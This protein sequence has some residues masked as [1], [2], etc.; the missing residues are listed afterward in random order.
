MKTTYYPWPNLLALAFCLVL[1]AGCTKAYKVRH[2]LEAADRDFQDQKYDKAEAEYQQALLL[3]RRDPVA[4]RQSVAVRQLGFIYFEEG[5]QAAFIYLKIAH[6][7]DNKNLQVQLKLAELYGASGDSNAIPLLGPVLQSD[8]ANEHALLLLV[9]LTQTN[10]L[11]SLRQR[12]ETQLQAGGQGAAVYHSALGWIDLRTQKINDAE[13]ELQKAVALD[14][15]LASPHLGMAIIYSVH[16]DTNGLQQA[17]KTAAELSPL[18]STARLKYVEFEL[19]SGAEEQARQLLLDLTRQ[20]PDYIPAWLYL[21]KL[22]FATLK[23]EDCKATIDK[24]LARDN[25]PPNFDATFQLGLLALAQRDVAKAL[26]TFQRLDESYRMYSGTPLPQVKYYLARAHLVNHEKQKAIAKLNETLALDPDYAPAV[27]LMAN[28]DYRAG[29]YNEAI[30]LLSQLI[31]KHPEI[32]QA[33]LALAE[34]FLAQQRPDRALEVYQG[35]AKSFASNAEIPRRMGLIYAQADDDAKARAAFEKSLESA[36]DYLPTLQNIT[37]LDIGEK[38][39]DQAHR[40]LTEVMEKLPKAAEPL[41]LQG[42]IY[43]NEGQTNLAESAYSKAIELNPELPG[44]YLALAQ[45][46]LASHQEQQ[47]L[48]RLT[49]LVARTNDV[50]ALQEIGEIHQAGGRYEQA[51]DIYE[52]VLAVNPNFSLALNNLA[53]LYSEHLTNV[54]KALQL[55]ER[56]RNLR[57]SDPNTADTLGWILYKKRKYAH[58]LSLIQESAE[59]QPNDPEVQMH[60]GMAYYMMEEEKPARIC[61]EHALAGKVDY[62]DKELARRPLEVLNLDPAKATPAAIQQLQDLVREDPQDPVPLSRLASI[63]E[64]HGEIQKAAESLQTLISINPENWPAMIRLS[65]L[66]AE[67]FKDLRKA[68]ELAKS[69][70]SLA[71]DDGQASALLGELVYTSGDYPWALSLLEQ[72]ANQSPDEPPVFYHLA[73]A[74]YA[75]GRVTEADTA[76]QKAVQSGDSLPNLEQ[77]KQFQAMRAAFKDPAQAQASS[78]LVQ[79]I[80]EKEPNNV[81][82]LMVSALLSERQGASHEAEQTWQ[83]VIL[84]YPLFAPAMRELAIKYSL[85]QNAGDQNKAYDWAQKAWGSMRDDLVLAKTLGILAYGHAEYNRSMPLLREYD[86]KSGH[87]GEV[88]YYLGMD[89]YKLKQRNDSK[90]ALKRALELGVADNLAGQA[91]T[92]LKELQ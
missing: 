32:A 9:Q 31:Q 54:D 67:H 48:N 25:S 29:N 17:L 64:Q 49:A 2:V 16:K 61:L 43:S 3:E 42:K 78:V 79:Q 74:Y 39:F 92:V 40:R 23:Y 14:P 1:S 30:T 50:S 62:P 76:M 24:I 20:A 10:E 83:K 51:R 90:Q 69:A 73:L 6:D 18:R 84:I 28:L 11:A 37:D 87:D 22:S 34:V 15:K 59:K 57:P 44:A 89:Y 80:L 47:A 41:L 8:P 91:R 60:L 63:Q 66:N 56:G 27:L 88:V 85:S 82:A 55:A 53:Y 19:Q 77:A 46:Y 33:H 52:K 65:R 21:M 12:L 7:Q 38:R 86:E 35:M 36:P 4:V 5:R 70:H 58:A 81:P 26:S 45:L 75:L 68:L 71:P 72:A 13:T